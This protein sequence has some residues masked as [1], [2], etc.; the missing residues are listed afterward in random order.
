MAPPNSARERA[1][2]RLVW[3]ILL[4]YLLAIFEGAIRK[5]I[6]PQLGQYIFFI[7]DPFLIYAY[8]LATRFGMWP[9]N[10]SF[11]TLSLIMCVFGLLIFVL[12]VGAFG[13]DNTRLLLG[14]YGWRS[15]FLYVPLAFLI[16]AQFRREDLHLF[17]RVT[18]LLAIPI[19][20]LVLA[21]FS[22][23]PNA[24]INVGVAEEKELQFKSVGITVERIRTTGTFT[25]P[26]GQQQF[27]ASAFALMLATFLTPN[28]R[29][30][31]V[32]LAL[33][34]CGVL[35]CLGLSG[36]RGAMLHCGLV[37]LFA[38]SIAFFGKS[39]AFKTKALVV[40]LAL[41][42]AAIV[43]YPIVF[44]VGFETFMAR[45]NA[46]AHNESGIEGGVL[47]RAILGMFDF[48]RLLDF[49]PALGY[50]IGYGGNASI[51]LG[52]EVD[53]VRPGLLVEADFSRQMVD[54]GPV[55]G[56]FYIAIRVALVLWLGRRVLAATRREPDPLPVLLY[57][58]VSYTLLFGQITGNGTINA[59]G[60]LFTG[61]CIAASR[62]VLPLR[63]P[64]LNQTTRRG[65]CGSSAVRQV[66]P[67][68]VS[69]TIPEPM[70][71][72]G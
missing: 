4:I 62:P 33:S 70:P 18:L 57:A 72:G 47:G 51:M 7:R 38:M 16:G 29:G 5:Y 63:R 21:Q 26:A 32:L 56:L 37:G 69:R 45:W 58:Y 48:V 35:T 60:W 54:L 66:R 61:L 20:V 11:F 19:A 50:G 15:Y 67:V 44:P 31:W 23:S 3:T 28:R 2:R 64:N 17:A 41:A 71:H 6:A 13:L 68:Q 1:R 22:S 10:Q 30:G 53:G 52:A 12:Q 46:A 8:I 36:S 43:L 24:T 59:Y 25:S 49:V 55:F 14:V 39:S 42:T 34:A 65:R 9:R 40:P 27:I